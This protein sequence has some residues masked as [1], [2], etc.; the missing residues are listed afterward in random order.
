MTSPARVF[1]ADDMSR[2]L[3]RIAHEI[4]ERSRGVDDLVILGIQ[5]RGV[6]LAHRIASR[7]EDIAGHSIPLGALD[8]T[9]YRDDVSIR[10]A[11]PV[12]VTQV[13]DVGIDDQL[14]VLVDDVLF[15]GRTVRAALDALNDIGRPRSVQLAVLIDRGH[16]ELPIRADY[17]GKNLPTAS[18]ESVMVRVSE[19]DGH[20]EVLLGRDDRAASVAS[21]G[22]QA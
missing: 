6:P 14:V 13:P 17:V 22:Y 2:V 15:S 7:I 5:S 18:A 10:G 19:I 3:S 21:D 1:D 12:G 11:R 16:R 9:M 20:D 8:V 4:I